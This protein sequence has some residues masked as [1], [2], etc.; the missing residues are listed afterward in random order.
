MKG[1]LVLDSMGSTTQ[2]CPYC[3]YSCDAEWESYGSCYIQV[4]PYR[5]NQCGAT[6]I[7]IYD[8]N[9]NYEFSEQEN[10]LGWYKPISNNRENKSDDY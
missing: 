9:E 10:R 8:N 5:C 3:G 7:G 2:L 1:F 4:A 6:E